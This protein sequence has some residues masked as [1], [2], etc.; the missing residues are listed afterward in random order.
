MYSP[1]I[2]EDLIPRV[3]RAALKANL[4][5]TTWVSQVVEKSL[6]DAAEEQQPQIP[7]KDDSHEENGN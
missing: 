7:R 2:R 4:P 1:K 3:Y 6:P 5:M